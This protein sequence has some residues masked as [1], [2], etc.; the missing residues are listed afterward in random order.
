M[1]LIKATFIAG[2]VVAL[3]VYVYALAKYAEEFGPS[4]EFK[5]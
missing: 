3:G 1:R 5:V 2:S 4:G